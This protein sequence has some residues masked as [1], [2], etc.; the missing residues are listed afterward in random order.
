MVLAEEGGRPAEGAD[1]GE[2]GE[3]LGELGVE[4]GLGFEV[5]EA[6][7]AGCAEVVFLEE[8]EDDEAEGDNGADV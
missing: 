2:A 5:E 1:G 4:G 3:G 6:H 8:V 7:L